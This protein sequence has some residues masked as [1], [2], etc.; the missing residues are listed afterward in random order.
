MMLSLNQSG[1]LAIFV[2]LFHRPRDSLVPMGNRQVLPPELQD[3]L[4]A[5]LYDD[6]P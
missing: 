2:R 5:A 1:I 4:A 3:L 6:V